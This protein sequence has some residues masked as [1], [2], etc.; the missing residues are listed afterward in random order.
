MST[1]GCYGIGC[2]KHK[3]CALYV[4]IEGSDNRDQKR[5]P[6][7]GPTLPRFVPIKEVKSA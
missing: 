5:I 4:A 6:M 2:P 3:Q 7:C 1:T